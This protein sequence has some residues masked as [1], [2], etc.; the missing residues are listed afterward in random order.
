MRI[1]LFFLIT[2]LATFASAKTVKEFYP[3]GSIK[4]AVT[5]KDGKKNGVDHAFY[6]DGATLRHAYNYAYGRLHGLQQEYDKNALLTQ[7]ENYRHGRLD[8]RSRYYQNGLLVSEADYQNGL[9]DGGYREYFPSGMVRVEIFWRRGKATEGYKYREDGSRTSL[10]T[11]T[12]QI[13][14]KKSSSSDR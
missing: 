6:P 7:E 14:N 12:L 8:G 5:Y 10:S 2:L 9:L 4:S 11:E 13:L 3:D 1:I